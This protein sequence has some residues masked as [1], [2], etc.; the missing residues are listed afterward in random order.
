MLTCLVAVAACAVNSGDVGWRSLGVW[1]LFHPEPLL[2]SITRTAFVHPPFAAGSAVHFSTLE[3]Y[4]RRRGVAD[5][6]V[7]A[8]YD[9]DTGKLNTGVFSGSPEARV[10][11]YAP[12]LGQ[13]V[14]GTSLG[15][16]IVLYDPSTGSGR[17]VYQFKGLGA[18]LHAIAVHGDRAYAIASSASDAAPAI[19]S[20]DLRN[21]SETRIPVPP[22]ATG[23]AGVQTVDPTG[24]IWW[25]QGFEPTELMW[26][27]EAGGP[28]RRELPAFPGWTPTSWDTW[29]GRSYVILSRPPAEVR[30]VAVDLKTL[31]PEA[32]TPPVDDDERNFL[33]SVRVDLFHAADDSAGTLYVNPVTS[34]FFRRR[35]G[36][37][38]L[39]RLGA[40]TLGAFTIASHTVGVQEHGL[41]WTDAR[42]EVNVLG[43]DDKGRLITW[44]RGTKVVG[45]ADTRD[46]ITAEQRVPPVHLSAAAVTALAAGPDGRVYGAGLLTN[47]DVFAADAADREAEPARLEEAIPGAEGQINTLFSGLDGGVFGAGYPNVVLFRWDVARPWN[48][49]PRADSNPRHLAPVGH[50]PQ[51]R[52]S[53]GIQDRDGRVWVQSVSDYTATTTYAVTRADFSTGELVVKTDTEHG[54][55]VVTDLAVLDRDRIAAIGHLQGQPAVYLVDARKFEIL[56]TLPV[57]RAWT[58]VLNTAPEGDAGVL[59]GVSGR[60]VFSVSRSGVIEPVARCP[61]NVLRLIAGPR[62]TA[63]LLGTTFIAQFDPESDRLR[64]LWRARQRGERVFSDETWLPAAFAGDA[65]FVAREEQLWRFA[66]TKEAGAW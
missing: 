14:L 61:G 1:E 47:S 44:R 65:L 3:S 36:S 6:F 43:A 21:G 50:G 35:P 15:P 16:S 8:R 18:W 34:E 57:D 20:I 58:A 26:H 11:A 29:R 31:N 4:H 40:V 5:Q 12:A 19:V 60:T 7:F 13:Y 66:P 49:G 33:A 2:Q 22:A 59:L 64:V 48:P 24:R 28:R 52:A 27:D 39:E 41:R 32:A 10:S 30:V 55:P 38:H 23:W 51:M 9:V 56:Q 17:T 46:G 45:V 53:R 37:D 42:G 54:F 63:L 62:R 25:F